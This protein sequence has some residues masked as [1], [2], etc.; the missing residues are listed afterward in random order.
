MTPQRST[1]AQHATL[2]GGAAVVALLVSGCHSTTKAPPP[3]G[4]SSPP[5]TSQPATTTATPNA[6]STGQPSISANRTARCATTDLSGAFVI[7]PGSAG[8]GHITY[9]IRLTNTT[10]RPC[11]LYGHPGLL[12][13]GV[14]NAPVPTHVQWNAIVPN[15]LLTLAPNASASA[16]ARFSPDIPGTGDAT[17]GNCQPTA[18]HIRIT[19]P[20]ETTSLVATVAPATPV[21][22]RGALSVSALAPGRTA[23][24][25]G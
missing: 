15:R 23:P 4:Q 20:D 10:S 7:T 21:C 5:T 8:A 17:S 25:E 13:L 6:S 3:G 11:T 24:G 2:I 16:S 1:L 12:L 14:N 19:P 22:E 18:A 9:T